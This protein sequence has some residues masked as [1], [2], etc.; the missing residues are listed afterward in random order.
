MHNLPGRG[1]CWRCCT[2]TTR[3]PARLPARPCSDARA[4]LSSH[5][6]PDP[7]EPLLPTS[8]PLASPRPE[9]DALFAEQ[10]G[11][12]PLSAQYSFGRQAA[13]PTQHL[14]RDLGQLAAL[15]AAARGCPAQPALPLLSSSAAARLM[16]SAARADSRASSL[17][18]GTPRLSPI[19]LAAVSPGTCPSSAS[20]EDGEA[21][22]LRA[23]AAPAVHVA[24]AGDQHTE[25]S[26][27]H[28]PCLPGPSLLGW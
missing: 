7:P 24:P 13:Q 23:H 15:Q 4:Y 16:A 26:P 10:A 17:D 20:L 25:A 28:G 18:V 6:L 19:D 3:P 1:A 11:P 8:G 22:G 9:L 5:G 12:S 27:L 2:A 14:L 21:G